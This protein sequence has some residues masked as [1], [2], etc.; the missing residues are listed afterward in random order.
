MF[1]AETFARITKHEPVSSILKNDNKNFIHGLEFN[2][3]NATNIFKNFELFSFEKTALLAAADINLNNPDS[4]ESIG[5]IIF[6][7]KRKVFIESNYTERKNAFS[8]INVHTRQSNLIDIGDPIRIGNIIDVKGDGLA[9]IRAVWVTPKRTIKEYFS[10]EDMRNAGIAKNDIKFLQNIMAVNFSSFEINVNMNKADKI[11]FKDFQEKII[12]EPSHEEITGIKNFIQDRQLQHGMS[13]EKRA[14]QLYR[15]N[16]FSSVNLPDSST[17]HVAN[18]IDGMEQNQIN[19]FL[20]TLKDDLNGELIFAIASLAVLEIDNLNVRYSTLEH[21]HLGAKKPSR[22]KPK[23]KK[24]TKE[25]PE[26]NILGIVSISLDRELTNEIYESKPLKQ[27]DSVDKPNRKSPSLHIVRGHLFTLRNG[28]IVYRK[29]HWRGKAQTGKV[30]KK[31]K[32]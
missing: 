27:K 10:N 18:M 29:P 7:K 8:S 17:L 9:S 26:S 28:K 3:S 11:T 30:I 13:L 5:Q 20:D 6:S 2:K 22:T 14:W 31:V 16:Q 1:L 23:N 21:Q 15:M 32:Q 12:D 4:I 25:K 19:D 24:S